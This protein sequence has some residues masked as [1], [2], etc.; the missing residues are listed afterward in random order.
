MVEPRT[1]HGSIEGACCIIAL[2]AKNG[3]IVFTCESPRK[4]AWQEAGDCTGPCLKG[5]LFAC[6]SD[7][8]HALKGD[9]LR[10]A[11][12]GH[13]QMEHDTISTSLSAAAPAVGRPKAHPNH[14]T[15]TGVMRPDEHRRHREARPVYHHPH[16]LQII[17]TRLGSYAGNRASGQG[18]YFARRAAKV[19]RVADRVKGF[20]DS[21]L[22][23]N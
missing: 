20:R 1:T 12:S 4:F 3:A 5:A 16:V 17:R 11:G 19:W 8:S 22:E 7:R 23:R 14:L 21:R 15:H 9:S 10:F 18:R 6:P 13:T 2:F